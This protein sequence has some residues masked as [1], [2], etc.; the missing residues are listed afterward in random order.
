MLICVDTPDEEAITQAQLA[1]IKGF[2]VGVERDIY[3]LD[4]LDRINLVSFVDWYLLSEL[5]RNVDSAFGSSV[6]MFKD[7]E[8]S[9]KPTD[10]LL[11]LGPLWDFDRS[12]G[13]VNYVDAWKTDGCWA[14]LRRI[15][16]G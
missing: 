3:E 11:N 14:T 5:F 7:T 8:D 4:K 16:T 12:A 9:A 10:R 1:F 15:R 6:F 2:I 13:N